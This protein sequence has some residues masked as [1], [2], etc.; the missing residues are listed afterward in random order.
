MASERD[1]QLIGQYLD[2][3]MTDDEFAKFQQ[4]LRE[5]AAVRERLRAELNLE[6]GL[7][8]L[9][10]GDSRLTELWSASEGQLTTRSLRGSKTRWALVATVASIVLIAI[11]W[12]RLNSGN[13]GLRH[14]GG[15]VAIVDSN[16]TPR[17]FKDGMKLMPGD[18]IKTGFQDSFAEI[19]F[20]DGTAVT[21]MDDSSFVVN[22]LMP[23]KK[24]ALL[25]GRIVASVEKQRDG[26]R[27]I[28]ATPDYSLKVLGT[29]FSLE[30]LPGHADLLVSKG[31]VRLTRVTDGESV[32]VAEGKRVVSDVLTRDLV[33]RETDDI[34]DTWEEDFEGGLPSGWQRGKFVERELPEG[35]L[36]AARNEHHVSWDSYLIDSYSRWMEGLFVVWPG[37]H[38]LFT[39]KMDR[40]GW[41]NIFCMARTNDAT[42]PTDLF[43]CNS[44]P[45][46]R[47]EPGKW[48]TMSVPIGEWKRNDDVHGNGYVDP[49]PKPGEIVYVMS[50]SSARVDRGLVIDRVWVTRDGS[51]KIEITEY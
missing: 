18:R 26:N 7:R 16:G 29:E 33:L 24:V 48:Y 51:G 25:S 23:Q 11:A 5:D 40:P 28:I 44:A 9:T 39:F 1:A 30:A 45:F 27:M 17:E 46:A 21:I 50:W 31:Q 14:H 13:A 12:P 38:I 4:R 8:D 43:Q 6:S 41:I 32:L 35:S 49:P 47:A 2:A 15:S 37:T 36:G 34:G 3:D 19:V 22:S 10:A 42:D 20:D